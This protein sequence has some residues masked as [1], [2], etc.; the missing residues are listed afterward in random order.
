MTHQAMK[1]LKNAS[2][3]P[4]NDPDRDQDIE[5]DKEDEAEAVKTYGQR[6]K[7]HPGLKDMYHEMREDEKDHFSKLSGALKRKQ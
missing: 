5:S 6:M 2:P 1:G 7:T 3:K 4:S